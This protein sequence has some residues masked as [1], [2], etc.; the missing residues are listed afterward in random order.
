MMKLPRR[1]ANRSGHTMIEALV[2]MA[3]SA[4]LIGSALPHIDTRREQINTAI[5]AVIADL[6]FARARSITTGTHYALELTDAG[7]YE[8][9]RL[10]ENIAGEWVVD[11]IAK[12]HTFPS[13]IT[14]ELS[15]PVT[16]EFNTRGMMISSIDTLTLNF[17]D[18][19]FGATHQ[20][21]IWPSGQIYYEL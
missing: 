18:T 6:R 12:T 9:Q 2:T 15:Q 21:S 17:S 7:T 13:H 20:V 5:N 19:Q 11:S 1:F 10:K 8:L 14:L 16:L 3:I 4:V